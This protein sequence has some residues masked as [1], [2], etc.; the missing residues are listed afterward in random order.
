[1][2]SSMMMVILDLISATVRL[3]FWRN[4]HHMMMMISDLISYDDD[5]L[6]LDLR[7]CMSSII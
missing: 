6:R 2:I 4:A 5:A 7:Y 3:L 1:M